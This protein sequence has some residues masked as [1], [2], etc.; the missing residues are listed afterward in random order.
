MSEPTRDASRRLRPKGPSQGR[1]KGPSQGQ[2]KGPSQGQPKSRNASAS[3]TS[4]A[5]SV[6][7]VMRWSDFGSDYSDA[8]SIMSGSTSQSRKRAFLRRYSGSSTETAEKPA[9]RAVMQVDL[10]EG[11]ASKEKRARTTRAK[12]GDAASGVLYA[13]HSVEE[14]ERMALEDQQEILEVASKSSNLKGTFQ[15]ALKCRAASLVGIVKEMA[16]RNT[17]DETRQLQAKVDNLQKEV[18]ALHVRVAELMARPE[19][20]SE[21]PVTISPPTNLE[22][23]IRKVVTEERAF[24]RACFAGIEDRLLPEKR[25][26]PPLAAD[27]PSAPGPSTAQTQSEQPKGKGKGKGK[28]TILTAPTAR[29]VPQTQTEDP[30]LP[31]TTPSNNAWIKVVPRKRKGKGNKSA[32]LPL[33]ANPTALVGKRTKLPPSPKT[34]AV[35][36]TL[37]PEA[38]ERG[39]TYES[40]LR[41]ART[42]VDPALLGD[43]KVTCRKTQTGARIFE[44]PGAQGSTKADLFASK[45]KEAVEDTAKVARPIK[46]VALEVTDL[47]DS[48]TQEEVVAAVAAAGG[49]SVAAVK[50]RAIRPGRRGM[51]TLR[52]ECPIVAAKAVLAKGR[53]PVGFSSGRVRAL[54]HEPMRCFKCFGIGHTRALCPSTAERRELC[55]RCGKEGHKSATCEVTTPRCAVCA[56][57]GCPAGHVMTGRTCRPPLRKGKAQALVRPAAAAATGIPVSVLAAEGTVVAEPY[58]VPGSWLGDENGLVA[59]LTRSSTDSPP[60]SLLERGPGYVAAAWG[61]MALIGVY[62]SPN[63]PLSDFENFLEVLAMVAGRTWSVS[64]NLSLLNRGTVYTCVRREGGSIVDLAFASPS[65]AACVVDWRVELAE[66]LSDHRYVRFDISTQGA[67]GARTGQSHF[68]RW[69]LTRLDREAATETAFVQDWLSPPVDVQD[70]DATAVQLRESL[71]EVCNSCM[72]RSH[73]PPPRRAVYWWTEEL[74]V[75]RAVCVAA[76]RAYTRSRRRRLRDL[77]NEDRLYAAYIDAKATLTARMGAAQDHAR[78]EMLESLDTD[79]FGR[80]YKVA[81]NKLRPWGPPVAETLEPTL[82]DG[83]VRRNWNP[84]LSV[85]RRGKCDEH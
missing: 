42:S 32:P 22:D 72:P 17:S 69:A 80:P 26:R 11:I 64:S 21:D 71:T 83:V 4:R 45:L 84:N 77:D 61:D 15:K 65:L 14:M 57:S 50:G 5:P 79:P 47:D 34:A 8:E 31:S 46:C 43:G 12:A 70:V 18:S 3:D 7:S 60:L 44:F 53:L 13:N 81:R 20:I 35:V 85:G 58:S 39:E 67:Q 1:S 56:A 9:K 10:E 36:V 33:T 38:V 74:V 59:L 73:R 23:I 82:L 49:C 41:R 75:L 66:T 6:A 78:A 27:T 2:P 19:G 40:V 48:V 24:T 29:T 37:T 25:I 76:R 30:L 52:L 62:F 54:E 28:K 16:Q 51:G 55:F 63:R 68:P